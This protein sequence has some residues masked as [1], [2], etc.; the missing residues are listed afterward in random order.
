MAVI[1]DSF[2]LSPPYWFKTNSG[3]VHHR[4]INVQSGSVVITIT[5]SSEFDPTVIGWIPP[6]LWQ[7][8]WR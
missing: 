3:I 1:G 5:A 8:I 4:R 6:P 2:F 7:T